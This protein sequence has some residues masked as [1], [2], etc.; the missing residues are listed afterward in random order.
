MKMHHVMTGD[1]KLTSPEDT[2]R[3]AAQVMK[4]CDC[5]VLPVLTAITCI[6]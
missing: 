4:E 3:H 1:A 6:S 2:L 5:G